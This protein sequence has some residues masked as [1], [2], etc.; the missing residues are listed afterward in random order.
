MVWRCPIVSPDPKMAAL[1]GRIT[2]RLADRPDFMVIGLTGSQGSGKTTLACAAVAELARLGVPAVQLSLDDLYLTR[3]ERAA[4]ARDVHPLLQTRGVP[5]THDVALGHGVLDALMRGAAVR[6]PCFDK[7]RDD[8]APESEWPRAPTHQP[9]SSTTRHPAGAPPQAEAE[10]AA[11]VN[12]LEAREDAGGVWRRHVNAQLGGTYR[13]LFARIDLQVML[14]APSFAVVH[15][16]RLQQ[17]REL[18]VR[19]AGQAV[20]DGAQIARFIQHYQRLTEHLLREMPPRADLLFRL[21]EQ[22][23]WLS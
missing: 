21:D 8:R 9:S 6:L 13:E 19:S 14:A 17:E 12:A 16:W 2:A 4:L 22:R 7:A 23:Q 11:P 20:M 3:A 15:G 18:A 10:L 1:T 5:G